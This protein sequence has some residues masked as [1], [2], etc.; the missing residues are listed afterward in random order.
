VWRDVEREVPEIAGLPPAP[1]RALHTAVVELVDNAISHS[2]GRHVEVSFRKAHDRLVLEVTDDGEG[3]YEHLAHEREL[4]D[5]MQALQQLTKGQLTTLPEEH[6]GE[7]L[8]LLSKI[9]DFFE[10]ESSGLVWLVDN[11]IKDMGISATNVRPGTRVRF[12]VD[13]RTNTSIETVFAE[14]SEAF[15]LSRRRVVV[16]LF[17]SGNRFL[18]RAEAKKL[19]KGLDSFRNVIV[20]FKGVDAVGQGFVDEMFRVWS[21]RHPNTRLHP[22]NMVPPVAFMVEHGRDTKPSR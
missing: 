3:V 11:E 12:E 8:F 13:V 19:L 2:R 14:S 17:D 1:E 20:D 18:S 15:E 4:G 21:R 7:G 6:T 16:K 10:V 9:A 5:A 22:V